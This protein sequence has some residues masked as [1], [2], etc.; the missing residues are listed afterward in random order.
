MGWVMIE[1]FYL[2]VPDIFV[3]AFDKPDQHEGTVAT[4]MR[5]MKNHQ[6]LFRIGRRFVFDL[7]QR[8]QAD[9]G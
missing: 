3:S 2:I 9:D 5:S 1:L 4:A 7:S 8:D 6:L